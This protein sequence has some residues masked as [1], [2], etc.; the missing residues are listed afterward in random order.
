M[1]AEGLAWRHWKIQDKTSKGKKRESASQ[2]ASAWKGLFIYSSPLAYSSLHSFRRH[3]GN[4]CYP[5]KHLYFFHQDKHSSVLK[6]E[7]AVSF[8]HHSLLLVMEKVTSPPVTLYMCVPSQKP[9]PQAPPLL[10]AHVRVLVSFLKQH[11]NRLSALAKIKW[12]STIGFPFFFFFNRRPINPSSLDATPSPTAYWRSC[13]VDCPTSMGTWW[14]KS[15]LSV[16]W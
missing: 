7:V 16:L 2:G 6:Q 8:Q 4:P 9:S 5:N 15:Y 12:N 3:L 14:G 11:S 13:S 10:L 1:P